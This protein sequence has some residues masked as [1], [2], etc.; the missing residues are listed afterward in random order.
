LA[1]EKGGE[2]E[3]H[4]MGVP[5]SGSWDLFDAVDIAIEGAIRKKKKKKKRKREPAVIGGGG[6]R[7]RHKR[8]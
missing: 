8:N 4:L 7:R 1:Q 5:D 2:L 6:R 3:G